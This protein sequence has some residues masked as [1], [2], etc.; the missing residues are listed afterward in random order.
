M[1]GET[2]VDG[3]NFFASA[4]NSY[5]FLRLLQRYYF[6]KAL[7]EEDGVKFDV[8]LISRGTRIKSKCDLVASTSRSDF[9]GANVTRIF[10]CS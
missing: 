6:D 3:C 4:G 9:W 2:E 1:S 5:T 7:G 8:V 10:G